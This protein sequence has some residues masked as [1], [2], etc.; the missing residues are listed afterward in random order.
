MQVPTIENMNTIKMM[1]QI[2]KAVIE[3]EPMQ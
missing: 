1:I 3:K 2:T